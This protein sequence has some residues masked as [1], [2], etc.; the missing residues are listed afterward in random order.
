MGYRSVRLTAAGREHPLFAGMPEVF[1]TFQSHLD[2]VTALPP[3][4]ER[5]A[6]NDHG[7]QAFGHSRDAYGVQFHPEYSLDMAETLLADK[8]MPD[9]RREQIAATLTEENAAD[10]ETA[11]Q[12]FD[13]LVAIAR[14]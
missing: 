12:V 3:E 7:I 14:G 5:L 4:A 2:A 6:E 1:T 10:A 8:E 9:E 13:N 11:R